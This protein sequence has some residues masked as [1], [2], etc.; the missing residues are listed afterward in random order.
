VVGGTALYAAAVGLAVL[1][2]D[3]AIGRWSRPPAALPIRARGSE[4]ALLGANAVG[5]FAFLWARFVSGFLMG[6]ISTRLLFFAGLGALFNVFLFPAFLGF[7]YRPSE[8]GVRSKGVGAS[9]LI[10]VLF[11]AL[12]VTFAPDRVAASVRSG[13][14]TPFLTFPLA[15]LSEEFFR[16]AWQTRLGAWWTNAAFGWIAAS[17]LWAVFHGPIF[18]A[19]TGSVFHASIGVLQ[20]LPIGLLLGYLSHR[21][22]S[23]LPAAVVHGTNIWGLHNLG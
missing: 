14:A 9:L 12:A 22:N 23:F 19:A 2:I 20:I 17:G 10:V 11:G 16:F 7:G 8:I 6:S 4:L 21:T 1:I 15:G 5:A 3:A 13:G 18:W